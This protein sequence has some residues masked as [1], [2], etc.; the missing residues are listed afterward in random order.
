MTNRK[1]RAA[2]I[3]RFGSQIET[4]KALGIPEPRLSR[5]LNGHVEP[6]AEE[7]KLLRDRLGVELGTQPSPE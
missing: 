6:K 1:L 4:A 5:L 2:M 7:I 3:L